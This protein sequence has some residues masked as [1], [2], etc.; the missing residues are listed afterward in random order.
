M[1][2]VAIKITITTFDITAH[3]IAYICLYNP[4]ILMSLLNLHTSL[5]IL[6]EVVLVS[7]LIFLP[8]SILYTFLVCFTL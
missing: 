1:S 7:D 6:N 3:I 8:V 2:N 5:G 4:Y